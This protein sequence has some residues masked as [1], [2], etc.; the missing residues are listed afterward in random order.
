MTFFLTTDYNSKQNTKQL[1]G[2]NKL[3]KFTSSLHSSSFDGV[4]RL[5]IP[6]YS[7]HFGIGL[8]KVVKK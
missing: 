1:S 7:R 5:E 8:V 2:F 6:G 4:W 3:H